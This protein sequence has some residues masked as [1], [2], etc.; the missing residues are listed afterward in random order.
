MN[1]GVGLSLE[2]NSR[3]AAQEAVRL[4]RLP[5]QKKAD[6]AILFSS[7]EFASV[8]LLSAVCDSL[9][10][11]PLVGLASAG[12]FSALGIFPHGLALLLVELDEG[13]HFKTGCAEEAKARGRLAGEETGEKLLSGAKG[14]SRAFCLSFSDSFAENPGLIEGLKDTLGKS[15]PIIG[16]SAA[17]GPS[18]K[19]KIYHHAEVL[20]DC[21]SG[22]LWGGKLAFGLGVK[23]G[24][25]PLGKP[26]LVTRSEGNIIK[27]IDHEPA[28]LPYQDYLGWD[29]L[30]L[31]TEVTHIS[32][33]YPL[34]IQTTEDEY[35]LRN[36]LSVNEEG[37]LVCQTDVPQGSTIR[38]MIGTKETCLAAA[39]EAAYEAKKTLEAN[40]ITKIKPGKNFALVFSSISRQRLLKREANKELG[41][42]QDTLGKETPL[43]GI[44]TQ[45]ELVP[46][47]LASEHGKVSCH[48]QSIVVLLVGG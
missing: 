13:I 24:F 40:P 18:L 28:A 36:I 20:S 16:I 29:L 25:R 39:Q 33:L 37:H 23:H 32:T 14:L 21:C 6:L 17:D 34:G 12:I 11:V 15:F 46:S 2:K 9:A 5:L 43:I 35:L 41:M 19:S 38:L 27:T 4:A 22:I 44:Y 42:L 30:R 1:I 31:Q 26:R 3:L 8:T 47:R 48:N 7:T 10:E 45:T